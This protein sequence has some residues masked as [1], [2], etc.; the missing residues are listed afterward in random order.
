MPQWLPPA[1]ACAS[2]RRSRT[3][4]APS[5]RSMPWRRLSKLRATPIRARRLN[6]QA[7]ALADRIG[8]VAAVCEALEA[9][10]T[11]AAAN[12]DYASALRL[13][14]TAELERTAH[15]MPLHAPDRARLRKLRRA[16]EKELALPPVACNDPIDGSST[17]DVIASL[18][19]RR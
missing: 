5:P 1:N 19:P 11:L 14:E 3:P 9:L 18:L 13:I 2:K 4:K 17:A 7:L 10:A 15:E 16:A 8:H 12:N 6:L